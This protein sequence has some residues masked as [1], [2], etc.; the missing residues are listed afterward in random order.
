M[1]E[2]ILQEAD[3]LVN[4]DRQEDYGHPLDDFTKTA[5]MW[6]GI[7]GVKFTPEEVGL[8]MC[9]VKL[10]RQVNRPKRDNMTDLAGYAQTVQMVIDERHRR[11]V[12]VETFGSLEKYE[13]VPQDITT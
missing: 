4:G 6:E 3:R 13:I 12:V 10:S 7:K 2:T 9:C 1:G 11:E 5:K 8:M